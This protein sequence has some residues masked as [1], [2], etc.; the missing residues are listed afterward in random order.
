MSG[1]ETFGAIN[2]TLN[3]ASAVLL[4]CGYVSIHKL[5][6][7]AHATFMICALV[8]SAVF[9]AC[10]LYAHAVY[11]ERSSRLPPSALRT[12]YWILLASHVLLSIG[13]LPPIA[14]TVWRAYTRNFIKHRAIARPTFWVWLYVSVT[15]VIVYVMLYHVFPS[16][17]R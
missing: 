14:M 15:G 7:R 8:T 2:A 17:T 3:A 6:I 12:I 5:K 16:M 10:Y 13:M 4:V 1:Q 9:L 11:P